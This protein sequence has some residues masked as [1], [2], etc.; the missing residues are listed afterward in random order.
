M[1]KYVIETT[2]DV[3]HK[4]YLEVPDGLEAFDVRE[5]FQAEAYRQDIQ[6]FSSEYSEENVFATY[7]V[8]EFPKCGRYESMN[9]ATYKLEDGVFEQIVRW[10]LEEKDDENPSN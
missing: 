3:R 10:D 4:Y 9:A 7:Q 1:T 5:L 8:D 2:V 6:Q